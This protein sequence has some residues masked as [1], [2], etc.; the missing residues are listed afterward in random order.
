MFLHSLYPHTLLLDSKLL[1]PAE[2]TRLL[3]ES[4]SEKNKNKKSLLT[5]SAGSCLSENEFS[6]KPESDI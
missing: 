1:S 4:T 2:W 6:L 3:T 5:N